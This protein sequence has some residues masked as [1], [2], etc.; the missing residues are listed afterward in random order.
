VFSQLIKALSI[1]NRIYRF[2]VWCILLE[3]VM[4]IL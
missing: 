1:V 4:E 3:L 2:G